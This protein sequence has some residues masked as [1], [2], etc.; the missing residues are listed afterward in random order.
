M[1]KIWLLKWK[2]I[3]K[4]HSDVPLIVWGLAGHAL[5]QHLLFIV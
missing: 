2:A 4:E 5:D 3:I 1:A